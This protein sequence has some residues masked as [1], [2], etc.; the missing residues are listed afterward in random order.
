MKWLQRRQSIIATH[1][2][3]RRKPLFPSVIF[4]FP[5]LAL[6]HM[7]LCLLQNR[8]WNNLVLCR[9][10]ANS[11]HFGLG[12]T[13]N[14]LPQGLSENTFSIM[15]PSQTKRKGLKLWGAH[16][17]IYHKTWLSFLCVYPE[18]RTKDWL[19]FKVLP[20]CQLTPPPLTSWQSK[21]CRFHA[22][23][24]L[25]WPG[26]PPVSSLWILLSSVS[27]SIPLQIS[28]IF[29]V[30]HHIKGDLNIE[31]KKNKIRKGKSGSWGTR[32]HEGSAFCV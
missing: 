28:G 2:Q 7:L 22:K 30:C 6:K 26:L 16:G 24:R 32:S 9:C 27:F 10:K 20:W 3:R 1:G 17:I 21:P 19:H 11:W 8:L 13:A 25:G 18:N 4:A 23:W 29:C 14:E 31:C 12:V 5:S 15:S